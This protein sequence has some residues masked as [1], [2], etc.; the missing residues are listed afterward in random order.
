MKPAGLIGQLL[1]VTAAV[2]AVAALAPLPGFLTDKDVYEQMSRQWI[3]QDCDDLQC[4]RVLVPMTLGLLPGAGYLKWR[5]Y[6]VICEALAAVLMGRWAQML[7]AGP[8]TVLQVIWL[9]AFGAGSLYTLFDPFTSDPL[10]HLAGPL[11][12]ILLFQERIMTAAVVAVIGVFAKESAAVPL[13][14]AAVTW[15]QQGRMRQASRA[16]LAGAGVVA[17]WGTWQLV[18]RSLWN[19]STVQHSSK[20]LDGAFLAFWL[21]NIG[22]ALAIVSVAA[23]LGALWI[24]WPAGLVWSTPD[25][26]RLSL[27][28]AL[29]FLMFNY[30]QQPDRAIWNFAFVAMPAAAVVLG[31]VP[32]LLGWGVVGVQALV[33]LRI[34]AQLPFVPPVRVTLVAAMALAVVAV[35]RARLAPA[36]AA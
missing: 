2:G 4:F 28:A 33:G 3:I 30:V 18:S 25:V 1:L 24:L 9:T 11:L 36:R 26:R 23:A 27:A 34:G 21:D 10:M 15:L 13:W 29:P 19:Y 22:P 20:L 12:M 17:V 5:A 16:L 7:G 32:P 35:W 6:A 14:V 8:R 31:R